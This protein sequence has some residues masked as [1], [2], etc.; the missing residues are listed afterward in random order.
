MYS[1]LLISELPGIFRSNESSLEATKHSELSISQ[2]L[3]PQ[4]MLISQNI[5]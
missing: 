4:N 3:I 1:G 2:T 5:V